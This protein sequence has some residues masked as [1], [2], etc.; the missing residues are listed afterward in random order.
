MES[1]P[2]RL[3][4]DL[5]IQSLKTFVFAAC[6]LVTAGAALWLLLPAETRPLAQETVALFVRGPMD[7]APEPV[8]RT[9]FLVLT[10]AAPFAVL[11]GGSGLRKKLFHFEGG[12]KVWFWN[13]FF[14]V[15]LG[16]AFA[17]CASARIVQQVLALR[18]PWALLWL[19]PSLCVGWIAARDRS[20]DLLRLGSSQEVR[21]YILLLAVPA[22]AFFIFTWKWFGISAVREK[23]AF[24]FHLSAVFY[25][26]TQAVAGKIPFHDFPSLYGQFGELLAPWLRLLGGSLSAF[27]WTMSLLQ[28]IA[29]TAI[30][31]F[32]YKTISNAFLLAGAV[33]SVLLAAQVWQALGGW[34]DPYFQYWPVR[35]LFPALALPVYLYWSGN[36]SR[37]RWLLVSLFSGLALVWN[38]DSGVAV[39]GSFLAAL[40]FHGE[41]LRSGAGAGIPAAARRLNLALDALLFLASASAVV[42]LFFLE[43]KARSGAWPLLADLFKFQGVFYSV[44]YFMLPLP[45]FYHP[46]Q[47]LVCLYLLALCV[48][49]EAA[50]RSAGM[51]AEQAA[52]AG[53]KAGAVFFLTILGTGLFAYYQGRSHDLNLPAVIWPAAL[54]FFMLAGF[55]LESVR[56]RRLP[57]AAASLPVFIACLWGCLSFIA[58]A[59]GIFPL[60]ACARSLHAGGNTDIM[61]DSAF[62]AAEMKGE[63]ECAIL[64]R[65]QAVYFAENRLASSLRGPGADE[66]QLILSSDLALVNAQL[67]GSVPEHL[68]IESYWLPGSSDRRLEE[69]LK[70]LDSRYTLAAVSSTGRLRHYIRKTS[71]GK[72]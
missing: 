26:V 35:F 25:P 67:A 59:G 28:F 3:I 18:L 60:A 20:P 61:E 46:W 36:R 32:A 34:N 33:T 1:T 27:T 19:L 13:L 57:A 52:S 12:H 54:L 58:L 72:R 64:S 68:F 71:S 63:R 6:A 11:F 41:L 17:V 14:L 31:W 21:R 5:F 9:L 7:L 51:D 53:K 55:L 15:L 48:S 47:A 39:A 56:R 62:I 23:V 30:F 65:L 69:G 16:A 37:L 22:A 44:G 42:F 10:L 49:V 24:N 29:L 70:G 66:G 38:L 2:D 8:E 50:R 45:G 4:E 40:F 43:V